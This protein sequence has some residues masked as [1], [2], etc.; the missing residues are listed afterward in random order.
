MEKNGKKTTCTLTTSKKK[1][2]LSLLLSDT[3]QTPKQNNLRV[4]HAVRDRSSQVRSLGG[5][6]SRQRDPS[7]LCH[8]HVVLG[9]HPLDLRG[10]QARERKHTDLP[11][12]ERPVFGIRRLFELAL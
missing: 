8:V 12:D 11:R 9:R 5:T 4:L 10:R 1:N 7:V 3:Q 2:Y 6:Q